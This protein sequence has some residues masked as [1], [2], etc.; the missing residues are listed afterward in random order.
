MMGT[1]TTIMVVSFS[2]YF[3]LG[4]GAFL[5]LADF[6]RST[7]ERVRM[8]RR[9]RARRRE[10][11]P[12][13][14][15]LR[16][17][18]QWLLTAFGHPVSPVTFLTFIALLFLSILYVGVRSV[19][20]STALALSGMTASLPLLLLWIRVNSIRRR[21]SHEGE[22]L[23]SEFL[24]EYRINNFNV[25]ETIEKVI[26]SPADIKVTRKLLSKLLYNLRNTGNPEQMKQ[27]TDAF[28]Y[29]IRTNW[30]LMLAHDIYLA[31][32]KGTNIALAVEDILIQLREA[33]TVAEERKRLNSEAIRMIFY[34]VPLIYC[35]TV[36]MAIRYLDVPVVKLIQNQFHTPEGLILFL[37]ILF[38]F[39]GNIALIQLV[40]NQRFDY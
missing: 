23:V 4:I 34:M 26:Q 35:V 8:I 30:S 29:G 37:F 20:I 31:A 39:V 32:A 15:I 1:E 11:Q 17:M 22:R 40:I 3:L 36:L 27:A 13:S 38:M 6:I 16:Q 12:E 7:L 33:R 24:R 5:L 18:R 14:E 9:L 28:A 19:G 21:G 2:I 10:A 25:Y